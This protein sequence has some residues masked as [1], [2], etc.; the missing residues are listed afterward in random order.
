MKSKFN[1]SLIY[2][3]RPLTV[4]KQ[5]FGIVLR[6]SLFWATYVAI[7]RY[8]LCFFKNKRRKIDR[9]NVILAAFVCTFAIFFE[10]SHRRTE[11]ALYM[12]PRFLEATFLFLHK[13]HLVLSVEY[14]EVLLFSVAMGIIMFF[15]QN[16]DKNI[17]ST[18]LSLFK[19]FW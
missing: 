15:Y 1:S 10:P 16:E 12:I 5:T 11:L 18:Y 4:L 9:W 7:F 8:S 2:L 3:Y 19:R 6:S 13:H 17:N 14:G